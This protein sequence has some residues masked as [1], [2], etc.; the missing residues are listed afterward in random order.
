MSEYKP[1]DWAGMTDDDYLKKAEMQ[2][3][4]SAYA[5][6]NPHA[7]AHKEVDAAYDDAQRRGKPWLYNRAWNQAYRSAGYEPSDA[8]LE[9][10]RAPLPSQEA[11]E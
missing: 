4:L 7:P 1:M 3:W 10:A 8:D 6:N 11:G 9:A 2:I 5:S